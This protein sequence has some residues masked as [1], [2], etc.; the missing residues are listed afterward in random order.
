M[1]KIFIYYSLTGNGDYVANILEGEG[2]EIRR[3]TVDPKEDLPKRTFFRIM[4]GGFLAFL[5]K[6]PKLINFDSNIEEYDE[7]II[8]SPIW[9]D[10]L[11]C[12]INTALSGLNLENKKV[13]FIFYSGSGKNKKATEKI[14]NMYKNAEIINI[15]EPKKNIEITKE[16]LK[17]NKII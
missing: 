12:P 6:T 7:I 16:V 17:E 4:A 8:G 3:I 5:E 1:N 11:A 9:N 15:K 2:I 13:T 10:R 14:N